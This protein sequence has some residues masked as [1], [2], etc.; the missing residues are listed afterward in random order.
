MSVVPPK[1]LS[2]NASGLKVRIVSCSM[3]PKVAAIWILLHPIVLRYWNI[4]YSLSA[5]FPVGAF[6]VGVD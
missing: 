6:I 4:K 5:A 3:F 1:S 2:L